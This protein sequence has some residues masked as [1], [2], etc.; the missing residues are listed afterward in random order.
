MKIKELLEHRHQ[1]L[2]KILNSPEMRSIEPL[3]VLQFNNF[4]KKQ[5]NGL[6]ENDRFELFKDQCI[7]LLRKYEDWDLDG[8]EIRQQKVKF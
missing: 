7:L 2:R 1:Y 8:L 5:E 3:L 6:I 4:E